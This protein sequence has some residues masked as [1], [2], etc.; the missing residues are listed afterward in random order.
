MA[1]P[2]GV[3]ERGNRKVGARKIRVKERAD[4]GWLIRR[5]APILKTGSGV[6][7]KFIS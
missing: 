5:A 2:N 7:A 4:W 6:L 1:F 3:W